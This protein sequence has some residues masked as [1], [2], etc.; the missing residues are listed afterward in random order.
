MADLDL[1]AIRKF[2]AGLEKESTYRHYTYGSRRLFEIAASYLIQLA[3]EVERLREENQRLWSDHKLHGEQITYLEGLLASEEQLQEIPLRA[4]RA[5][6][7]LFIEVDERIARDVHRDVLAWV[8]TVVEARDIEWCKML[9]FSE[10]GGAG[11]TPGFIR[12]ELDSIIEDEPEAA[13]AVLAEKERCAG[14][15][16]LSVACPTCR[17]PPSGNCYSE[18]IDHKQTLF[19]V[20]THPHDARWQAAIRA[21]D[22]SPANS[23]E[24]K[25][26][27]QSA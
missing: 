14:V 27:N 24:G 25:E 8:R 1:D 2:A 12:R 20:S 18:I 23:A 3:D 10:A 4:R 19:T 7:C 26:E 13:L 9:E 6:Q 15:D 17:R 21:D 22:N 16:P 5:L 11:N